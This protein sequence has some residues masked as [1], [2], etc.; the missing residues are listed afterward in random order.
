MQASAP[1]YLSS[2]DGLETEVVMAQGPLTKTL[3]MSHAL[4]DP[5]RKYVFFKSTANL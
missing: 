4:T 2:V 1:E 3:H 5:S